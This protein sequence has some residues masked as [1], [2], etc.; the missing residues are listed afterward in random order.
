[1]MTSFKKIIMM[2]NQMGSRLPS[3]YIELEYLES[4]GTQYINIPVQW[5]T[6]KDIAVTCQATG[7]IGAAN[8]A[9]L[10]GLQ[11]YTASHCW[12]VFANA[13][14]TEWQWSTGI[15]PHTKVTAELYP[16][17]SNNAVNGATG[18]IVVYDTQEYVETSYSGFIAV[19]NLQVFA[20]QNSRR[21]SGR[22]YYI[23][24]NSKT[25]ELIPALRIEDSKPG[26]Y[27]LVSGQFFVNQGTGEF[28]YG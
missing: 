23:A 7:D 9:V 11:G 28:T 16:S 4:T 19:S 26:M 6:I 1:M 12:G 15:D 25:V 13:A 3:D 17:I 5:N 10:G 14:K 20:T 2:A 27:D 21:F 22:V 18:R 8:Q 24:I